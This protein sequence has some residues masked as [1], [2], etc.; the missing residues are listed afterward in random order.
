MENEVLNKSFARLQEFDIDDYDDVVGCSDRWF[1]DVQSKLKVV[2]RVN[3]T[4]DK[5]AV[6]NKSVLSGLLEDA[7]DV[8]DRQSG[9]ISK[10]QEMIELLKTEALADKAAVGSSSNRK[11]TGGWNWL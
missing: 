8:V 4:R 1:A 3:I 6:Q 7:C 5:F 2:H 9:I 11:A 10:M